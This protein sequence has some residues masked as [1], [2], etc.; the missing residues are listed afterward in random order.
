MR[1]A[2][3]MVFVSLTLPV[4]VWADPIDDLIPKAKIVFEDDFNRAETDDSKEELGPGW[5][6]STKSRAN[7]I[8]Q[9]DLVDGILRVSRAKGASHG[10][11]VGHKAPFD[12]GMVRLRF[13]FFNKGGIQFNFSD[14]AAGKIAHAGHVCMVSISPTNVRI[15]DQITGIYEKDFF[16]RKRAGKLEKG[17][18]KRHNE[19]KMARSSVSLKTDTWYEVGIL[20]IKDKMQVFIDGKEVCSLQSKGLDHDSKASFAFAIGSVVE[21]DDLKIWSL[22]D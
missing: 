16:N 8:K 21:V 11:I 2:M 5:F 3:V 7:G 14:P 20:V 13:K 17:E 4:Q 12:D 22:D 9:A 6:T 15:M 18:N 19:G 10:A 1:R